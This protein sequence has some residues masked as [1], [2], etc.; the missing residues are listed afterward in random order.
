[1][2]KNLLRSRRASSKRLRLGETMEREQALKFLR[3]M[4]DE[5]I[6]ARRMAENGQTVPVIKALARA[7]RLGRESIGALL[8]ECLKAK[9]EQAD[10]ANLP[11]LA[12][13]IGFAMQA[14][15]PACRSEVG[16]KWKEAEDV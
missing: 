2:P 11:R 7:K 10:E 8:G 12:E 9:T 3:A 13:L 16:K 1:M 14:L 15:C 5:T 6:Q 4:L